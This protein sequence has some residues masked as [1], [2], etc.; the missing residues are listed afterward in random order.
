M[1]KRFFILLMLLLCCFGSHAYVACADDGSGSIQNLIT[2][3]A[4]TGGILNAASTGFNVYHTVNPKPMNK[5]SK[6]L[7]YGTI[8]VG[9]LTLGTGI[10]LFTANHSRAGSTNV[11]NSLVIGAGVATIGTGILSLVTDNKQKQH[12]AINSLSPMVGSN[13]HLAPGL[14][15]GGNF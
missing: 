12:A 8:A 10:V 14:T 11:Y 4:I 2:V 13:N 6:G 15:I 1:K 5:G 7:T 3:G 9:S